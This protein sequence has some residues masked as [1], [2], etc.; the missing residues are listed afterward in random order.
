M[1]ELDQYDYELPRELIA[2]SPLV[3]RADARLLVVVAPGNPFLTI[4]SATCP[5]CSRPAIAWS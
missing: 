5:N 4:I 2:Q 1:G 3:S